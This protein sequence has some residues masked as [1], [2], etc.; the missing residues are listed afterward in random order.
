MK[1]KKTMREGNEIRTG[2]S[3]WLA[4]CRQG[5]V[6]A[7]IDT[8]KM[9]PADL[10][11]GNASYRNQPQSFYYFRHMD[12]LVSAAIGSEGKPGLSILGTW[13]RL[14]RQVHLP[15]QTVFV[16]RLS[17]EKLRHRYFGLA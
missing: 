9:I 4:G 7:E 3:P 12:E 11:L 15:W 14:S 17:A 5:A 1:P 2:R 6:S 13:R 10:P 16:R 8:N